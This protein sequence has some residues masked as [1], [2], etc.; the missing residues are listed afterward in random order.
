MR[1]KCRISQYSLY[2]LMRDKIFR[3]PHIADRT[4]KNKNIFLNEKIRQIF[5]RTPPQVRSEI[6][7]VIFCLNFSIFK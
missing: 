6:E 7:F 3:N 1:K 5:L 2:D 4:R